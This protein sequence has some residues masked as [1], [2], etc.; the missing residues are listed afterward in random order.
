MLPKQREQLVYVLIAFWTLNT[1]RALDISE[2]GI[3]VTHP[4]VVC[5]FLE[6]KALNYLFYFDYSESSTEHIGVFSIVRVLA[7]VILG[8]SKEE[9]IGETKLKNTNLAMW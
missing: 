3:H 5:S 2:N 9:E 8:S 4:V 7:L 1:L 6:V